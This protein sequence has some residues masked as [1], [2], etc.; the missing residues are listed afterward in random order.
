MEGSL[1]YYHYENTMVDTRAS[2]DR[3]DALMVLGYSGTSD[4]QDT[5]L[6]VPAQNPNS[7]VTLP[8]NRAYGTGYFLRFS[9]PNGYTGGE[10]RVIS[11]NGGIEEMDLTANSYK[12]SNWDCSAAY[13]FMVVR[14]EDKANGTVLCDATVDPNPSDPTSLAALIA[15]RRVLRVEDW[16]VDINRR[17]VMPKRTGD[18]CY[19]PMNGRV[20]QYG[21]ITCTNSN[22]TM[23]PHFVSVCIKR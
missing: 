1:R 16:F 18:Y 3:R 7:S 9:L 15:I 23:C 12:A 19:G 5:K 13:Q 21:Q 8:S 2:L 17:C 10:A 11:P 4:S 20:I 6:R 22:S 14:P